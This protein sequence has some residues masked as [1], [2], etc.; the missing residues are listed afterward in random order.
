MPT[1]CFI[2]VSSNIITTY[3]YAYWYLSKTCTQH[4]YLAFTE[5]KKTDL[6]C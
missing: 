6:S 3:R 5:K 2:F 1:I 4:S